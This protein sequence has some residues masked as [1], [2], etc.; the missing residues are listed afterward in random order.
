MNADIQGGKITRNPAPVPQGQ[1]EYD[2]YRVQID[3]NSLSKKAEDLVDADFIKVGLPKKT[4]IRLEPHR[5]ELSNSQS[6][7]SNERLYEVFNK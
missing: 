4:N 7:N 6:H 1:K 2:L 3:P 5:A